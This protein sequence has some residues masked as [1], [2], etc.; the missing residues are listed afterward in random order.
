MK[1]GICPKCQSEKVVRDVLKTNAHS[2]L[3]VGQEG[4]TVDNVK[5]LNAKTM[6]AYICCDCGFTELYV[7]NPASLWRKHGEKSFVDN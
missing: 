4:L 3:L 7:I 6:E 5:G 2:A 1:N